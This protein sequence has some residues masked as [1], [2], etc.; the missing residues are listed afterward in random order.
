MSLEEL[1]QLFPISLVEQNTAWSKWYTEIEEELLQLIPS[2]N[3]YAI[4]HIGSTAIKNIQAKNIIDVVVELTPESDIKEIAEGLAENNF[5]IM[6]EAERRI[7]LNRGYTNKGFEEKAYHVHLRYQGDNDEVFF[8]DY[9]NNHQKIALEY[10]RLK[11]E[12]SKK[13]KYDRN[14]YSD[15]KGEFV[16]KWTE[17]AKAEKTMR[18]LIK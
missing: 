8:R 14:T 16:K 2:Q 13:Y 18:F 15:K 6:S 5:I 11:T 4:T 9:L 1:W 17:I 12:L 7:S 10:E 3:L